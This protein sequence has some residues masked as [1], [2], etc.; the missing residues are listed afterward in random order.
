MFIEKFHILS[1]IYIVIH[2]NG[3]VTTELSPNLDLTKI[4]YLFQN[5]TNLLSSNPKCKEELPALCGHD[6]KIL[7]NNVEIM[8]CIFERSDAEQKLSESCQ[9]EIWSFKMA[10]TK[11]D[12]FT[13]ITKTVCKSLLK[14]NHDCLEA[15]NEDA[16]S[17]GA[18][19]LSCLIDRIQPE[20]EDQCKLYLQQMELIIFSDYRLINKFT[21]AC[22]DK[23]Q[24][25]KCGRL[26]WDSSTHSQTNTI[27]CLQKHIDRLP[28][29]C[30]NEILRISELQ[31][32]DFHLDKPLYF[33][34]REDRERFCKTI[35]S[36]NG[37]VYKCLMANVDEP[38]LSEECKDKLIQREQLIARDYKVSK[39]LV[40]ACR[41]DIRI[42]QCRENVK[43]RKEVRLSQILLC[44]ENVH[45][46]GL[47]LLAECQAEMLLHRR[48]LFENYKLT[49]DLVEA[50]QND[51]Q[52]FCSNVEFGAKILH[53]LM[54]YAKAKRRRGDA[55][56]RRKISSNCQREV[57]QLL[58]EVNIAEDW[59]VDPVLQETCQ[60][61]VDNLCKHIRP[62]NGRI[63]SCLAEHIDSPE[64]AEECRES[65]NQMQYFVV[66]NFELD[67]EIYE[68]CHTDAVKY[69]HAHQN[70]HE[71]LS[72]MD[73]ERGP[74]VMACL[75]RYVYQ[76]DTTNK[77]NQPIQLRKQC[78][79]HIKR[80][81]KQRASSVELLPFIEVP[82]M[83]DLAKY[84]SSVQV[85]GKGYEMS[86]LQENYQQLESHCRN[87]I[88]NFT[89]AQSSNFELNYPLF[90]S[91]LSIVKQFCSSEYEN[92]NNNFV[93]DDDHH[94]SVMHSTS[95]QNEVIQCLI[96]H[97]NHHQVKSNQQ[98]RMAIEH[99]QLINSKDFRFDPKFKQACKN[100]IE[101][102]CNNLR[103]KYDIIN[104]LSWLV[105]NDSNNNDGQVD[106]SKRVSNQCRQMLREELLQL[107]EDI[108]LDPGLMDACRHDRE[109]FC[110]HIEAGESHVLECLKSN[111]IRLKRACQ[112]RLFR[113]QYI[114]QVDNSVDYSL[115]SMCKIAI[116][117]YCI[118]SDLHDV[119]YCLRDH[120]NDPGIGHNC[121]SL[122][123]KRLAQQNRDYRLNPRLKS[124]CK[125]EINKYCSTIIMK[126]KPDE[127]LDGKVIACLKQQYLHNTLSQSCEIEIINIIRE[128]S[129][130]IELDP[131]LYR[132]CQREIHRK[133]ADESDI[134][135]CLKNRFLAK[136][137]EDMA[138]KHEIAR[139]IKETEADIE[140]DP[141][142]FQVCLADLKTFCSDV[143]PGRG[144]QLN[145]LAIIHRNSP[146]RLSPECDTLLQKR[147][148]LF[149]YASEEYP[150]AD[151]VVQVFHM[152]AS[153][154]IHNYL[155]LFLLTIILFIF[156]F[157]LF[158][159][160]IYQ[161]VPTSDKIK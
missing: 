37:R 26:D 18:N 123:L 127:L 93:N 23:I 42:H 32:N 136:Q 25:L 53:C 73:P 8:N 3:I 114:E 117:K 13:D 161:A 98:C 108:G 97:K 54:K 6:E 51:I 87:A 160:R 81:M 74:T 60:S 141:H 70:W 148:Q 151:S 107:N 118:L 94:L 4:R 35:E 104:C 89:I 76:M 33:A 150:I 48:F 14:Q 1:L 64:M 85:F 120:R 59:R 131:L 39:S 44:L 157:G 55:H 30:Q 159:G 69:C 129:M 128:V 46:K 16:L 90:K 116:D 84:C 152:V 143:I 95:N 135:E 139:L 88:G 146:H 10:V 106:D 72:G 134:H 92:E 15:A 110:A 19:I 138:C 45:S 96:Q 62:G 132:T 105:Y 52:E 57:E 119:L 122:V 71:D 78:V 113:K 112:R 147:I 156:L 61:T 5:E 154:P 82:C 31:S 83:Q 49:P 140:S 40:Q 142:L 50:C 102:N 149:E 63:L 56:V 27:Q 86:C 137:I 99:F 155:Y 34:C 21:K 68:A 109:E 22:E 124:S 41:H 100:D 121:R 130:N 75:Y 38:D 47:P 29:K 125:M 103:T 79:H 12:H 28:E 80:V 65:L 153:S 66:R 7:N 111:I 133:C 115:L 24:D 11:L 126:S 91:C 77:D 36:G 67:S 17:P 58:K 144:H 43:G 20:T 101:N 145:C 2:I 158:C 9:H